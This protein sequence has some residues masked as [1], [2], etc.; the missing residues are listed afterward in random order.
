MG[1]RPIPE[2][3]RQ[4]AE[5]FAASFPQ[6]AMAHSQTKPQ[7]Q[8]SA[9]TQPGAREEKTPKITIAALDDRCAHPVPA[10][11]S[12]VLPN[13][14]LCPTCTIN[15]YAKIIQDV[16]KEFANRGGWLSSKEKGD[17]HHTIREEWRKAKIGLLN[18]V[19]KLDNLRKERLHPLDVVVSIT[20]A[21]DAFDKKK[22]VLGWVPGVKYVE[23]AEEEEPSKEDHE[24]AR[25]FMELLRMALDKEM[26][27]EDKAYAEN[28]S[29][30]TSSPTSSKVRWSENLESKNLPVQLAMLQTP[31]PGAQTG[32]RI[33][34][35]PGS[36]K[37]ILKRRSSVSFSSSASRKRIRIRNVVQ[38]APSHVIA[39]E[40]NDDSAEPG[41]NP[42]ADKITVENGPNP[43]YQNHG[44]HT[45]A[46]RQRSRGRFWRP[47]PGYVPG[48]WAS[49]GFEEKVNTSWWKSAEKEVAKV[50]KKEEQQ[51]RKEGIAKEKKQKEKGKEA[52]KGSKM[53][54]L[55][56]FAMC[57]AKK[58]APHVEKLKQDMEN[59]ETD[60]GVSKAKT[61]QK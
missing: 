41:N 21:L 9:Q 29:T 16:Q 40:A 34:R 11:I 44:P 18:T 12:P 31:V 17:G 13:S 8:S 53:V 32:S 35:L 49:G 20:S 61:E 51:Q 48:V 43:T 36:P 26:T 52:V 45:V 5:E 60:T 19:T 33:A 55:I 56:W 46:E 1:Q 28:R 57:W 37:S 50:E 7:T 6:S 54:S 15:G 59:S 58:V 3:V 2:L 24:I 39:E 25:M 14:R 42:G 38:V 10:S 4:L 23:G 30:A 27:D 22:V 47:S